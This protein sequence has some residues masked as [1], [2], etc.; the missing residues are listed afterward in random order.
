MVREIKS[1]EQENFNSIMNIGEELRCTMC[2]NP[3][4]NFAQEN[5]D[6]LCK[7]CYLINLEARHSKN[8]WFDEKFEKKSRSIKW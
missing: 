3:A 6:A 8:R 5:G 2:F 7:K 1:L 4:I